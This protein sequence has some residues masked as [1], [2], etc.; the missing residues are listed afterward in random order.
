MPPDTPLR[1]ACNSCGLRA[2]PPPTPPS[3]QSPPPPARPQVLADSWG[4]GGC[5]VRTSCSRLTG[6]ITSVDFFACTICPSVFQISIQC[7]IWSHPLP[8]SFA[9]FACLGTSCAM[10][11]AGNCY[12]DPKNEEGYFL[13]Y[14]CPYESVLMEYC[15]KCTAP[16]NNGEE[17]IICDGF[18]QEW[19]KKRCESEYPVSPASPYVIPDTRIVD[20]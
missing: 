16:Y 7:L 2:A 6:C 20:P 9:V 14:N 4:G 11:C 10:L 19:V 13:T 5:R 18:S 8:A 3:C 17:F 12:I 15:F 1:Y